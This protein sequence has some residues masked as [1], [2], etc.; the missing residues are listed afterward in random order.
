MADDTAALLAHLGIDSA[1]VV[2]Y[3]MGGGVALQL[4]I[5]HPAWSA[6][7][8]RFAPPSRNDGMPAAASRCSTITPSCSPVCRWRRLS[9]DRPNPGDFPKLVE[10]LSN[11]NTT[12]FA[13]P[14]DEIRAIAAPTVIVV[15]DSDGV[16]LEH[17]V[18]LFGLLGGGVMGDLPACRRRS[19]PCFLVPRT[20]CRPAPGCSTAPIGWW[21]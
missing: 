7:R 21:P 16:R 9:A 17:A 2:G 15:G 3:S 10:K 6:G 12:Q 20:S 11:S 18:E 8:G 5:R 1:D 4:A 19:S 13:W 14:E